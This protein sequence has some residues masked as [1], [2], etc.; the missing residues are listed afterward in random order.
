MQP[1]ITLSHKIMSDFEKTIAETVRTT[2][3]D[4]SAALMQASAFAA[5]SA[6]G[7]SYPK[8]KG[9]K[10][11]TKAQQKG[12]SKRKWRWIKQP[13]VKGFSQG[14]FRERKKQAK[15]GI[16]WWAVASVDVWKKGRM[17]THFIRTKSKMDKIVKVPRVGLAGRVW[18]A[19]AAKQRAASFGIVG[20]YSD[21]KIERSGSDITNIRMTNELK[22]ISQVAPGSDLEGVRSARN[23]MQAFLDKKLAKKIQRNFEKRDR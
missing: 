11:K 13:K 7:A 4:V 22:Y 2:R 1:T 5:A 15:K 20:N 19:T 9:G 6:A 3:K 10:N 17:T 8:T 12:E 21:T 23:R 16:P 18:R 14:N